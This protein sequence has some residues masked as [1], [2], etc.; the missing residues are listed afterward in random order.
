MRASDTPS[1]YS[2]SD[3]LEAD[4]AT[5]KQLME[6]STGSLVTFCA[7]AVSHS[8]HTRLSH[9]TRDTRERPGRSHVFLLAY[10]C[11]D[12]PWCG[13]CRTM[14]PEVKKAAAVLKSKGVRVAA[15]NTDNEAGLAQ[16]LGIR[17]FPTVRW[18][19][20]GGMSEYGGPRTSTELVGFA[21][22]QHAITMVKGKVNDVV[23][24]VKGIGKLAMS[25]VL[26]RQ[27]P[28]PTPER[29]QQ[30]QQQQQAAPAAA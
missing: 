21:L 27:Q 30:Q 3:V 1:E 2:G 28:S 16:S 6:A 19:A 24:G 17:G 25:K 8:N 11:A 9:A 18:V 7:F 14:V 5:L 4:G 23:K 15:V 29:M 12:A 10:A 13:H 20:N 22:Q 26:G